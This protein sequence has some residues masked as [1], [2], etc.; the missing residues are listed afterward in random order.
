MC[1]KW[2]FF[3]VAALGMWLFVFFCSGCNDRSDEK[4]AVMKPSKEYS[5][6]SRIEK[7]LEWL[8]LTAD[9]V[10]KINCKEADEIFQF[11]EHGMVA[12]SPIAGGITFLEATKTKNWIAIVPLLNA[13]KNL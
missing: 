13:D 3:W 1:K 7:K 10:R 12:A 2:E 11:L 6:K 5:G 9:V 8:K 4:N